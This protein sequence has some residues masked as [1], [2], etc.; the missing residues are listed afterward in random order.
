MTTGLIDLCALSEADHVD[1]V[2]NRENASA[3]TKLPDSNLI[4]QIALTP[5][6]NYA[7]LIAKAR[8]LLQL[9]E[10]NEDYLDEDPRL[11]LARSLATDIAGRA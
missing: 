11:V 1:Y 8:L 3:R 2:Q 9:C 4:R 10:V 5:S 7:E 6:D